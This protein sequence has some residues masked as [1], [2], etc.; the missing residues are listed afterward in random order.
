MTRR[1]SSAITIEAATA[2]TNGAPTLRPASRTVPH[3]VPDSGRRQ[4]SASQGARAKS[5]KS[6]ATSS[7]WPRN[8]HPS[9]RL[10]PVIAPIPSTAGRESMS[11]SGL[12]RPAEELQTLRY[13]ERWREVHELLI[14]LYH[15]VIA[16]KPSFPGADSPP[17]SH[18]VGSI[19]EVLAAYMFDLDLL[20]GSLPITMRRQP[21]AARSRS[22]SP[23]APGARHSERSRTICLSCA[24]HRI[25]LLRSCT[26][27]QAA[28][29]R[30]NQARNRAMASSW[31]RFRVSVPWTVRSPRHERILGCVDV[32]WPIT[33]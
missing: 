27:R 2:P 19:G 18:L 16:L 4:R 8:C 10:R 3:D 30:L 7:R 21:M 29:P 33:H 17:D 28:H 23:K 15:I 24:L 22:S 11:R 13:L 1:S 14:S 5:R 25:T 6:A 31:F 26:M 12:H 20:P 32:T 9:P